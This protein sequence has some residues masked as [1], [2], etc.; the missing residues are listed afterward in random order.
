MTTYLEL[1]VWGG[2][3]IEDAAKDAV[4]LA[5]TL[6]TDIRFKF[7]GVDLWTTPSST[8]TEVANKYR[9]TLDDDA[10]RIDLQ[11]YG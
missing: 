8:P 1:G 5:I 6:Q 3:S 11:T 2:T 10:K 7:N 9:K 4:R